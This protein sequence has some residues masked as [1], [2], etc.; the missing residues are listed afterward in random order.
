VKE[1]KLIGV[2]LGSTA[3]P[4]TLQQEGYGLLQPAAVE[5]GSSSQ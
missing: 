3:T 2:Q 1:E 5:R 4:V